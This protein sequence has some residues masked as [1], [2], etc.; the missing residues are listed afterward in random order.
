MPT[1][2]VAG[3][4]TGG[5]IFPGIAIARELQDRMPGLEV[6]FVG[7]ARGL[8][9]RIVPAEGFRLLT[10]RSAG[11][12]AK[13]LWSRLK[14]MGLVPLS[15]VQSLG[16][17]ASTRP[18]LVVGVG[19]YASGP[20]LAAA[21][22][23][24][25]PTLIHEQN[26]VPGL[27]NRWLAPWVTQVAVTFPGTIARLK[28]RGVVTGNPVRRAFTRIAPRPA[29]VSVRSLLVF[30][31]SQGSRALNRAV[32][33]D[34][35]ALASQR[36]R[37]RI[38]HQTGEAALA[39]VTAAYRAAGFTEQQADVRAFIREMPEAFAAADLIVCRSGA[40]T[41]AELTAAGRPALL[42]PFPAAAH[43]HQTF[44][45]RRLAEAG[46]AVV[47]PEAE[48]SGGRLAAAVTELLGD[49]ARLERMAHAA[50]E[51]ARPGAA[52]HLA[53]LC[54]ELMGAGARGRAA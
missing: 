39:E 29:G 47:V 50:H 34:L 25:I 3:G 51:A 2:L 5:H 19:G 22:L 45:A 11:I 38:V 54:L 1:V 20:V 40:T 13:G 42:V 12:T 44:N 10:I 6:L 28:G 18:V 16:L 23:R 49:P 46:A 27:T 53:D 43:D 9:S 32:V 33:A 35:P 37:L 14:G 4:G 41:V 31:G 15:L 17:I 48:L 52:A 24:R 30:G 36:D 8:E 26:D 7:T 21:V